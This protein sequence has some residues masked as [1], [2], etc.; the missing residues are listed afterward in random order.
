MIYFT[1]DLH[2]GHEN[3]IR[4]CNRPFR[5]AK[6]MDAT[7]M[8]NWNDTVNPNDEVYILGDLTMKSPDRAHEILSTLNGRKYFIRG[9][10]DRFLN[11]YES[12]KS[13]LVWIKDYFILWCEGQ[14]F[15]LFH[16]PI[17]EWDG[18]F[19]GAIHLYGHIHNSS[20]SL[21]RVDGTGLAFNV[22]VDCNDFRPVSMEHAYAWRKKICK[23][24]RKN[25]RRCTASVVEI[26]GPN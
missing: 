21:A 26:R 3:I 16:Y 1:A 13:D 7:L 10:H 19:R 15:V 22:G 2:F 18:F 9:N 11:N 14:K 4:Y 5:T 20:V 8:D 12:F 17:A 23:G 25:I 6:E 24:D